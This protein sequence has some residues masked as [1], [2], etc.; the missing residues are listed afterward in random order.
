[1]TEIKKVGNNKETST[2]QTI[3]LVVTAKPNTVRLVYQKQSPLSQKLDLY[4]VIYG[5]CIV[6]QTHVFSG[7]PKNILITYAAQIFFVE[8]LW[9]LTIISCKRLLDNDQTTKHPS[10]RYLVAV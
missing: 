2:I 5:T 1:M 3:E 10:Y 9:E 7:L 6:M 4:T 8:L